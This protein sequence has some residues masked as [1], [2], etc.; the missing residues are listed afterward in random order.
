MI[1]FLTEA[2]GMQ[3]RPLLGTKLH[4]P[5]VRPEL[6][7]RTRLMERISEGLRL[8]HKLALIFAPAGPGKTTLTNAW[9]QH[10]EPLMRVAWFSL[11]AYD[12]FEG[13]TFTHESHGTTAI[14][15]SLAHQAAVQG[16]L[17]GIGDLGLPLPLVRTV[18]PNTE[19]E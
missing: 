5:P 2:L 12:S 3:Q 7:A 1:Y 6:V 17:N 16:L 4:V 10:T 18:D 11:D 9:A 13:M 15:G 8:G 14:T 19:K